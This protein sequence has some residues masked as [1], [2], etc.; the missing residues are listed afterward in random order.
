EEAE[1]AA[2]NQQ[3]LP[4]WYDWCEYCYDYGQDS[5]AMIFSSGNENSPV[6]PLQ[7]FPCYDPCTGDPLYEPDTASNMRIQLDSTVGSNTLP[8]QNDGCPDECDPND[9]F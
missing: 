6:A 5:P 1:R 3:E 4:P 2:A 8:Q 7:P 9:D